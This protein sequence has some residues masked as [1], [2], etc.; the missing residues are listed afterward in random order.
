MEWANVKIYILQVSGDAHDADPEPL[1]ELL[2]WAQTVPWK[3]SVIDQ[4]KA[5]KDLWLSRFLMQRVK[6]Q[7]PE[8]VSNLEYFPS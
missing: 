6:K 8:A 1:L 3:D 2:H 5:L 7:D 4:R